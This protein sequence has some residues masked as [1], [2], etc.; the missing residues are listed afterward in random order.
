MLIEQYISYWLQ[1][2]IS[3]YIQRIY[4]IFILVSTEIH[5]RRQANQYAKPV[6]EQHEAQRF[7]FF[8]KLLVKALEST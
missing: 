6:A 8:Q 3:L 7:F 2:D 1:Q 5:H 4:L